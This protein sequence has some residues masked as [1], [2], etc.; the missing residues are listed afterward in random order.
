MNLESMLKNKTRV[1]RRTPSNEALEKVKQGNKFV[2]VDEDFD[3]AYVPRNYTLITMN[4]KQ[5]KFRA[6]VPQSLLFFMANPGEGNADDALDQ[7]ADFY[8]D[9]GEFEED[10]IQDGRT[11]VQEAN[12]TTCGREAYKTYLIN[13]LVKGTGRIGGD[14]EPIPEF[15]DE[16]L[17]ELDLFDD[18]VLYRTR[19]MAAIALNLDINQIKEFGVGDVLKHITIRQGKTEKLTREEFKKVTCWAGSHYEIKPEYKN[20]EGV[21]YKIDKRHDPGYMSGEKVTIHEERDTFDVKISQMQ[22]EIRQYR[23]G[24]GKKPGRHDEALIAQYVNLRHIAKQNSRAQ[25]DI[26]PPKKEESK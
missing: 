2:V 22:N 11:S 23:E 9:A 12:W 26:Q 21:Y 17:R 24:K 7:I 10:Q 8:G 13:K 6:L 18:Y 5:D 1:I 14:G 25:L 19:A 20:E 15:N 16:T 3:G 4:Y